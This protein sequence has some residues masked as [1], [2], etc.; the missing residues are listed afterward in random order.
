MNWRKTKAF[1]GVNALRLSILISIIFLF[2]F[3]ILIF[4]K[5]GRMLS[6][7][8]IL[9]VPRDGMTRGGIF[10]AIVGTLYLTIL[11]VAF[12]FPLGLLAAIYLVEYAKEGWLVSIIRIAISTLA[13][14]PSIIF[15]LFGL[16]VFVIMFRFGVSIL[17]G[18]LTLGIMVLP[19]IIKASEEAIKSV[20]DDFR[21]ASYALGATKS[22][23]I[24][25]VVIPT[26]LPNILTGAIMSVGR[27]AGETAPILFT[28]ATFYTRR[29]PKSIF[30]EV[31]VLPYHIYALMTEGTSPE[32]QGPIAY[33]TAVVLLGLVL[34]ISAIAIIIR[35]RMRRMK[36]W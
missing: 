18:S 29:L 3:I 24:I 30:D 11:A 2:F 25:K 35:Y 7:S 36:K 6:W 33:G 5:G 27:A 10:P 28:A 22:T 9:D 32:Y 8:F 34:T 23:T 16:A 21:E 15:G 14:V 26:A 4:S 17:S 19:I 1:F 13:G 20:P 31:M 12:A